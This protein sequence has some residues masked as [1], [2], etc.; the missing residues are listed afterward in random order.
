MAIIVLYMRTK[1]IILIGVIIALIC[2]GTGAYL[3]LNTT[4]EYMKITMNGVTFEVP[5]SNATVQN[6]TEH[7]STYN[8]T[9]KNIAIFVFDSENMGINDMSEAATFA[10]TREAFQTG[11]QLQ[12]SNNLQYNYSDTLKVYTYLTNYTHKNVF[13]ITKNKEDMENILS[14]LN[15]NSI[16]QSNQTDNSTNETN[17]TK[18][19]T[20]KKSTADSNIESVTYEEN[21]Q[22]GDGSYYR[23]VN[24]KDGNIRQYDTNGE[25][26]GSSYDSDQAKLRQKYGS[27]M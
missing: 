9:D 15:P 7:Y 3:L 12:Q 17:T 27:E 23:Q 1:G 13:I 11:A 8:D 22:A 2:I 25:L 26:I 24:Y 5:K 19:S 20:T 6:Q 18:T 16:I 10:T 14:K 4:P 21:L